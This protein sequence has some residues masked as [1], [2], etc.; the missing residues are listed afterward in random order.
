MSKGVFD[1]ME[2]QGLPKDAKNIK[3]AQKYR[4]LLEQILQLAHTG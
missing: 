4:L 2:V 1:S 3:Q